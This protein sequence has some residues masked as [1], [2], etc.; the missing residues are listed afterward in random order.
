[1]HNLH[2]Y[3]NTCINIKEKE[4]VEE[5]PEELAV[6]D[7]SYDTTKLEPLGENTVVYMAGKKKT[8]VSPIE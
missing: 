3:F 6:I 8:Y 5:S 2:Y 4:S 7:H 1:M